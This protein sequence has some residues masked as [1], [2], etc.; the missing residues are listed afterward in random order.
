MIKRFKRVSH[1]RFFKQ[2]ISKPQVA[3]EFFLS[4]VPEKILELVELHTLHVEKTSFIDS[5][6]G[7]KEADMLFSVD[8]RS[9]EQGYFYVLIEH[10]RKSDPLM[11]FR[12]LKYMLCICDHHIKTTNEKKLPLV[13][14]MI[15]YT[16]EKLPQMSTD[17]FELF[18]NKELAKELFTSPYQLINVHNFNDE[19]VHTRM[20]SG[21]LE[22]M[23]KHIDADDIAPFIAYIKG[24]LQEIGNKDYDYFLEVLWYSNSKGES[25]NI[26]KVLDVFYDA[27][28]E[29]RRG[30]VMT[31][32]QSLKEEGRLEGKQEGISI[33]KQEGISI[34]KQEGISIGKQEGKLEVA[35]N[36]LVAGLDVKAISKVTGL[37]EEQIKAIMH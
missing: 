13:Y 30:E 33:G 18:H 34:G 4:H 35:K 8:L 9:G 1:D 36:L 20:R 16:G 23:M 5:S 21:L 27:A 32:L 7:R 26:K 17:L 22:Y 11:A 15:Y 12:M 24:A 31:I 14:P 19:E 37:S 28:P 3:C 2:I 25:K 6:I 10:Q 29:E